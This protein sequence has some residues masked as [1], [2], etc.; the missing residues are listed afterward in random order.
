M[1]CVQYSTMNEME[2]LLSS[3][4]R[5]AK[6]SFAPTVGHAAAPSARRAYYKTRVSPA[7]LDGLRAT[8]GCSEVVERNLNARMAVRSALA[9]SREVAR[10]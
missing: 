2:L 1:D 7:H 5:A 8:P 9:S 6:F 3:G 10:T 4:C